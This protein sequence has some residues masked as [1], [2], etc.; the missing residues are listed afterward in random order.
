MLEVSSTSL[1]PRATAVL[2]ICH[3]QALPKLSPNLYIQSIVYF[4]SPKD[5]TEIP[6]K[7]TFSKND[8][9]LQ[10]EYFHTLSSKGHKYHLGSNWHTPH[11]NK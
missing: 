1:W 8:C 2:L 6:I 11:F 5:Q 4:S 3:H 9:F 10:G 7:L